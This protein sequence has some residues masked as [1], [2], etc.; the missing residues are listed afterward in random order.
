MPTSGDFK[1]AGADDCETRVA[2]L[3]TS[4]TIHLSS[5]YL[6][7]EVKPTVHKLQWA[8]SARSGLISVLFV[9]MFPCFL[10]LRGSKTVSLSSLTSHN[11]PHCHQW[12]RCLFPAVSTTAAIF[13]MLSFQRTYLGH[14]GYQTSWEWNHN[15]LRSQ[16]TK[17]DQFNG[18]KSLLNLTTT[19]VSN[20]THV[21]VSV[22]KK[23]C[24]LNNFLFF[25]CFY[26]LKCYMMFPA[27]SE[28][29]S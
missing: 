12:E 26:I 24:F 27:R 20:P 11:A 1:S 23:L 25:F 9:S 22:F 21:F 6:P 10:L 19:I 28:T 13:P 29:M 5:S 7:G 2:T 3:P 15:S 16:E 18:H 8:G 17:K 14:W 4:L